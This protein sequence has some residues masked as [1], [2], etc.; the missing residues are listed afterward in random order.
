[1]NPYRLGRSGVHVSRAG[2]LLERLSH[3]S[4]PTTSTLGRVGALI[5]VVR[6][7]A[8]LLPEARRAFRRHPAASALITAGLVAGFF[9]MRGSTYEADLHQR[10]H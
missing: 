6:L 3:A 10:R 7:G 1:M 5:S 8:Q 4:K 9:L 2:S